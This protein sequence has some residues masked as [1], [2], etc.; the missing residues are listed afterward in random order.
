M[1]IAHDRV[2]GMFLKPIAAGDNRGLIE[3]SL[4]KAT[5]GL[6]AHV[7]AAIAFMEEWLKAGYPFKRCTQV[8]QRRSWQGFFSGVFFQVYSFTCVFSGMF[9]QVF[10]LRCFYSV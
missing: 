7:S 10:S 2:K 3:D 1:T 9:F 4:C 8:P 5:G 6:L